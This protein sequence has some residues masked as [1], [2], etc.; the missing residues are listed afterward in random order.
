M[1][2]STLF[3]QSPEAIRNKI[4]MY[5]L[6]FG[7]PTANILATQI[8]ALN[9]VRNCTVIDKDDI[10]DLT[11]WRYKISKLQS[12]NLIQH[13]PLTHILS[14]S[15]TTQTGYIA[16]CELT[17]AYNESL[18][19]CDTMETTIMRIHC[20]RMWLKILQSCI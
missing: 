4:T 10:G 14:L 17:I 8:R 3:N 16:L 18:A 5:Y 11:L 7:T 9:V 6:G 1:E 19:C 15:N 2:I 12:S 20:A 13:G